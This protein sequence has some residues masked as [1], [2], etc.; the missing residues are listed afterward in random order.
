VTN[1]SIVLG[2]LMDGQ[3]PLSP[4]HAKRQAEEIVRR[5][6]ERKSLSDGIEAAAESRPLGLEDV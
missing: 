6:L 5:M 4:A 3:E 1:N 2:S